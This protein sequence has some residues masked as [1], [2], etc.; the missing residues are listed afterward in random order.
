MSE[1]KSVVKKYFNGLIVL[2]IA[3]AIVYFVIQKP[4]TAFNVLLVLLGFGAVIMI[5]EFGH[6]I[7][8]KLGGIK[9]E[10]FS[11]GFPPNCILLIEGRIFLSYTKQKAALKILKFTHFLKAT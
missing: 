11:I 10:A 2:I 5:H 7:V 8:A 4:Q 1:T 3:A 9:V 6:F